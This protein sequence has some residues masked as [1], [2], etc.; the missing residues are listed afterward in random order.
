MDEVV[1]RNNK[2]ID[3]AK[4]ANLATNYVATGC[5]R[6]RTERL[7]KHG[8]VPPCKHG[9]SWN[10]CRPSSTKKAAYLL[11]ARGSPVRAMADAEC[12]YGQ[13]LFHAPGNHTSD[14]D[15]TRCDQAADLAEQSAV[16]K[17]AWTPEQAGLSEQQ[18]GF[19]DKWR[20][21]FDAHLWGLA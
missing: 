16:K 12:R 13:W 1:I 11:L 6:R 5:S 4:I 17:L 15:D 14:S 7:T 2:F 10:W 18:R 21:R 19:Y 3:Y 8:A 9:T 20:L